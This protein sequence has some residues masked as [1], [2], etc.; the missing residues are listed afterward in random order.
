M[1]PEIIA[2]LIGTFATALAGIIVALIQNQSK[3]SEKPPELLVP[4]G[5]KVHRPQTSRIWKLILP[6]ESV[7]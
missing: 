3:K 7:S 1:K 6:L 2:S 5:Y 4:E